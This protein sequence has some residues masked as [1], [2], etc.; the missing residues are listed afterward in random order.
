MFDSDN[1]LSPFGSIMV[2]CVLSPNN[3]SGSSR[4]LYRPPAHHADPIGERGIWGIG[5]DAYAFMKQG[6]QIAA[7]DSA[8]R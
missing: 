5:P 1:M 2:R 8:V 6:C 4:Y 7:Q 3:C